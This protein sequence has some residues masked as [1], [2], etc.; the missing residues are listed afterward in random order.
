MTDIKSIITQEHIELL[1]D[2]R[3]KIQDVENYSATKY[4]HLVDLKEHELVTWDEK[5]V[6]ITAKGHEFI[7]HIE[8]EAKNF[9]NFTHG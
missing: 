2:V 3:R 8:K 1:G 5:L 4:K 9:L 7:A 6:V